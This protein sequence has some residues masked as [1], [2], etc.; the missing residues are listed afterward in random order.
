MEG[1]RGSSQHDETLMLVHASG[2]TQREGRLQLQT[3]AL[4]PM[5]DVRG[6]GQPDGTLMPV[7]ASGST[8]REVALH[9]QTAVLGPMGD[10]RWS[11]QHDGSLM[12]VLASGST[13][14]EEKLQLQTARVLGPIQGEISAWGEQNV[15]GGERLLPAIKELYDRARIELLRDACG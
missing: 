2:S 13:Q 9:L 1:V 15:G 14:R 3:T 4:G 10:V 8:Q 5:G 7:H 12:P 6:S 11:S